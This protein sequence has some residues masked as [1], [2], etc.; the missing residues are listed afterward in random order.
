MKKMSKL[1]KA[2]FK[3]GQGEQPD[4]TYFGQYSMGL[5]GEEIKDY[6]RVLTN[7]ENVEKVYLKFCD[8]AGVNTMGI[9]TCEKCGES[10]PLMYRH[11]VR[12]FA[13]ALL[14]GTPTYF[15]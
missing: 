6:L 9:Y 11:D 15:D 14:N 3:F 10:F 7:K 1:E 8:V 13:E 12:R 4:L 5:T 2:K